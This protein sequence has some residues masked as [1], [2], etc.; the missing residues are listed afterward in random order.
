MP[1]YSQLYLNEASFISALRYYG[2]E[3]VAAT[4]G[5]MATG[6]AGG[7]QCV[8]GMS[9]LITNTE[10][11]LPVTNR[12]GIFPRPWRAPVD[13]DHEAGREYEAGT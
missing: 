9:V 8:G 7:G 11:A 5:T 2:V 4:R 12:P 1:K 3:R 6:A 13:L 10:K